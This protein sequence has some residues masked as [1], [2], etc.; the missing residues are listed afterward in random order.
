ME[1][2]QM[3]YDNLTRLDANNQPLPQ[4]ATAWQSDK[5]GQEWVLTLREGV[6]FHG[7]ED[8]TAADVVATIERTM[9]KAASGVSYN[10]FGPIKA[11]QTEG[12][13]KVRVVMTAPFGEFPVLCAYRNCRILPA[14]GL[15]SVKDKPNGTGPF[16]FKEYQPGSSITVER[17]P[18]YWDRDNIQLDGVRMVFIRESVAMQAALRGGQVDLITQ[19][20]VET[21]LA[22]KAAHGFRAYSAVTG[23]HHVLYV[24]GNMAPFDNLKVRQAF[25]YLIDR[26]S[27]VASALFGLGAVGNDVTVP[28]GSFYLPELPQYE[29]D[30]PR[31]KKLLEEAGVGPIT[32]DLFTSSERQPAPK[33]AIACAEAAAKIGVTINVRDIPYTE[34]AANVSRKKPL[35][36]SYFSGSATLYDGVY[37]VYHSKGSYNYSGIESGAGTDAVL[38]S[39]LAEVDTAKRR[40]FAYEA[41]RRIHDNS[42]RIIPY[43]RNYI[44]VTSDKVQGFTPP[45]FGTIETR[46][47][48]F[49]A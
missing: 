49:S 32:L 45:K 30:L 23:D 43:F 38:D 9:D 33:M 8:F 26:K 16:I 1:F 39:M 13:Y 15:D 4:L 17:N 5:G 7:G 46:T 41:M 37:R 48:W 27:L 44:G 28:P 10:V 36:N 40:E 2:T 19:I 14:S 24:M 20:P 34:Y 18:E 12:K 42:D 25:R 3:V 11:V 29:Q 6:R 31:A 47:I 35:Y 22:M 21:Y